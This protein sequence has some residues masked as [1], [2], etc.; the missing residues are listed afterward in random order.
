MSLGLLETLVNLLLRGHTLIRIRR[1]D[2]H[3]RSST[4]EGEGVVVPDTGGP[5]SDD[6]CSVYEGG[7][8]GEEEAAAEEGCGVEG[9][10]LEYVSLLVLVLVVLTI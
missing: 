10:H 3:F 2:D 5:A 9:G 8:L 1:N 7:D 6:G 4:G